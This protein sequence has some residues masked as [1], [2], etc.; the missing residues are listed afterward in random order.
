ME[1]IKDSNICLQNSNGWDISYNC[2]GSVKWCKTWAKDMNRC[3]P[4]TCNVTRQFNESVCE[5]LEEDVNGSCVYPFPT[6]ADECNM[7]DIQG[8]IV[9]YIEF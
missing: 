8:K 5:E 7:R 3:C 6:L 2:N 1:A 4:E 9:F